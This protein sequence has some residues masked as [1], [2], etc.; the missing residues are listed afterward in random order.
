MQ[1]QSTKRRRLR[2]VLTSLKVHFFFISEEP[3]QQRRISVRW[4]QRRASQRRWGDSSLQA[5][6]KAQ[7][8]PRGAR[9]ARVYSRKKGTQRQGHQTGRPWHVALFIKM[10]EYLLWWKRPFENLLFP[11]PNKQN[12][13]LQAA[14]KNKNRKKN[15]PLIL[16]FIMCFKADCGLFACRV[17]IFFK[18]EGLEIKEGFDQRWFSEPT[19]KASARP[20]CQR[21]LCMK[22]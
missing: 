13:V 18:A 5:G 2:A 15:P 22:L 9:G 16:N 11:W 10:F 20:C 4:K 12:W 17:I 19:L 6:I 7:F 21:R 3:Q 14:V 8:G 1:R